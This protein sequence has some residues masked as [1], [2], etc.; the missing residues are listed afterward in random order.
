MEVLLFIF[1][2]GQ[3]YLLWEKAF[4]FWGDEGDIFAFSV[5]RWVH[6]WDLSAFSSLFIHVVCGLG[7]G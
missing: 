6:V 7:I 1:L 2:R 4:D 5:Y 3:H